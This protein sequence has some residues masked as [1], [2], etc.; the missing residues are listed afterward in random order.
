MENGNTIKELIE[1][2]DNTGI[3]FLALF[4]LILTNPEIQEELEKAYIA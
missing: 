1:N 2:T 4:G 3:I